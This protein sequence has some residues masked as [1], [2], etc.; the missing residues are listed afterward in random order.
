[1]MPACRLLEMISRLLFKREGQKDG[2]RLFQILRE[3]HFPRQ[4]NRL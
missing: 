1:M 3:S 4:T 2:S